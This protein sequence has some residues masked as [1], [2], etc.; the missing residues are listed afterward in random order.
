M[1][2]SVGTEQPVVTLQRFLGPRP[3]PQVSESCEFCNAE[4]MDEHS[5]VVNIS[6]RSILCTCR[7]CY[8]LFTLEGAA[9]GKYKAVPQ[10]YVYVS[11]AVLTDA[12]WEKFQ[13]PVGV[14]FFF[15]NSLLGRMTALYPGPAGATESML[16]LETWD[17]IVQ[18]NPLLDS[19]VPDVEALL[20]YNMKE[21]ERMEC[22]LVPIDACYELVGHI[23]RCW[24]GFDGGQEAWNAINDFFTRVR[25]RSA[26]VETVTGSVS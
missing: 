4:I 1:N 24:K 3:A 14:A 18:A 11:T 16:P 26:E 5:H 19:L 20:V 17:E 8:L 13:I 22:Y 7:A 6:T 10:R 21:R 12:Q 15:L 25:A 9:Q 2:Q 23:K